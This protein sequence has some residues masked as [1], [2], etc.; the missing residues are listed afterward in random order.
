MEYA[1]VI[2]DCYADQQTLDPTEVPSHSLRYAL[3]S[4]CESGY[5]TTGN[6]FKNTFVTKSTASY[7]CFHGYKAA[8][9]NQVAP[10]SYEKIL[11]HSLAYGNYLTSAHSVAKFFSGIK[12]DVV[13]NCTP[14]YLFRL[15]PLRIQIFHDPPGDIHWPTFTPVTISVYAINYEEA[16][17]T[18]AT[19][20]QAQLVVPSGFTIVQGNNPQTIGDVDPSSSGGASWQV[21]TPWA[22]GT[23]TFD[24]IVWCDNLGVAVWDADNPYHKYDVNMVSL[25]V[26]DPNFDTQIDIDDVVYLITYIFIAGPEPEPYPVASGDADCDC[27]ITID[28]VVYLIAYIFQAGSPPCSFE[29]WMAECGD[30][31]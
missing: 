17:M 23:Y 16:G 27:A 4:C 28:D 8:G 24:A 13:I 7:F 29:E 26:A 9:V 15:A 18:K 12:F 25:I 11:F 30:P 2:Q 20:V 31:H 22:E 21:G 19:N 5:G 10:D 1:V 3:I 6:H 14:N